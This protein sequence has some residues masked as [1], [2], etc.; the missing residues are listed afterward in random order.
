V[1]EN[2]LSIPQ[3]ASLANVTEKTVRDWMDTGKLPPY[4]KRLA[5][6][7]SAGATPPRQTLTN[8][9]KPCEQPSTRQARLQSPGRPAPASYR[10]RPRSRS[11]H[12]RRD[13]CNRLAHRY[14][15]AHA[16]AAAGDAPAGKPAEAPAAVLA[17]NVEVGQHT[18]INPDGSF[19]VNNGS[20][21]YYPD[22]SGQIVEV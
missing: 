14:D 11:R 9:S 21:R 12:Q 2:E 4:H 15:V 5:E 10:P 19:T 6:A 3:I 20:L 7:D 22:S 13:R 16:V 17:F 1:K 18:E 8:G